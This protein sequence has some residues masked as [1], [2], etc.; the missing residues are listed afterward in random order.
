MLV[1]YAKDWGLNCFFQAPPPGIEPTSVEIVTLPMGAHQSELC[2]DRLIASTAS[3]FLEPPSAT[4][5]LHLM[6]GK[7]PMTTLIT[8]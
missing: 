7:Q 1:K 8:E 4:I 2:T 5:A 3:F 6:K